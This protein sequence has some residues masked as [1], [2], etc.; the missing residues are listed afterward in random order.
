[1][2]NIET[3]YDLR[4]ATG[5]VIASP[6]EIMG[7]GF[8]YA[9]AIPQ[10]F[11]DHGRNHDLQQVCKAFYDYYSTT[12]DTYQSGCI[13]LAVMSQMDAM[14]DVMRRVNAADKKSYSVADLQTYEGLSTHLFFDLGDWVETTCADPALVDTFDTQLDKTFPADARLH[15]PQFY[16]A[17]G[18]TRWN[19]VF[20]YSGVSISEPSSLFVSQ[21]EQTNWYRAT[22]E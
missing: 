17:L 3:L 13:S 19:P 21:N 6:C 18:T 22:H 15:T 12:T 16:S 4:N 1:M 5:Y 2:A 20:A 7:T 9:T 10:L 11:L 8:P 14:A